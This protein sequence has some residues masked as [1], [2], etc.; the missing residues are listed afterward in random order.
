MLKTINKLCKKACGK[1]GFPKYVCL[2]IVAFLAIYLIR[3]YVMPNIEG[4]SGA[5]KFVFAHMKGCPHCDDAMPEW[6]KFTQSNK[7]AI[8]AVKI[9]SS[10]DPDFMKRHEVVGFPTFLLIS[11]DGKKI[12]EYEGKRTADGFLEFADQNQ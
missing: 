2:A 7:T 8:K 3:K 12:K 6:D 1:F 5:R 9:E 10:E 4:L 11:G